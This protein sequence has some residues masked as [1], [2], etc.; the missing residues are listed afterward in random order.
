MTTRPRI[1]LIVYVCLFVSGAATLIYELIWFR[2]LTLVFGASLYAL[3]A[4]LCAFMLGLAGGAWAM[5][6]VLARDIQA[7]GSKRLILWYGLL[8]AMIGLYAL[9][10]PFGLELLEKIYPLLLPADGQAGLGLHVTEF[11]LGTFLMLPATLLMGAT[12][13]LIGCWAIGSQKQQLFSKLSLLY[14]WNTIGAVFG[15]LFTQFFAI[16]IWGVQGAIWFAVLLNALVF[17][18]CFVGSRFFYP[19]ESAELQNKS[20]V[21]KENKVSNRESPPSGIVGILI[22]VMFAY[23]GMASLSSEILWTRILVFPMGTTLYSFALILA[24][25]LSGIALGSLAAKRLL[26]ESNWVLK[27]ILIEILIGLVCIGILPLLENLTEWTSLADRFFYSIEN[28]PEKTLFIRFLFAFGLMFLPTFGFGLLFPLA[29]HI[30]LFRL[31]AVSQAIG[32]A[33]SINTL[34]GVLGTILTP[35]VFIPLFGIR[36]SIYLIYTVLILLGI[37]VLA[38]HRQQKFALTS[39]WLGAALVLLVLGKSIF[40]PDIETK[41]S[42]DHNLARLE[43]NVPEDKIQLLDYKEGEFSTIS[44]VE[45]KESGARTL[46]LDGFSTAT[47]SRSFSGSTYMQAMGFVPMALHPSPKKV[48]VIGFG[49]GNT[50]GIASLFPGATIHGV[51]I[52]KNVLKFSKWFSS[53]NHDVLERPNTRVFIQDGRAFLRWSDIQYDVIIMEPMSPLQAGVVNLYSKE[54]YELALDHLK[55]D[56]ILVQW[57]PLHLVGR[58]DARSIT[59]TFKNVFPEFSVWNSFLTRIVLLIGSREKV[60]IDKN[61]FDAKLEEPQLKKVAEEMKVMSFLDFADFFITDGHRLSGFLEGAGEI[62]DDRPLLE[63]STVSLLPPLKW[64]TDESF[65]NML[66]HR[67][68]QAPPVKGLSLEEQKVFDRN[69]ML[70]T[71]QRL[72]VF[73][74]RYQGPGEEAFVARNYFAGLEEMNIYFE[75]YKKPQVH[76]DEAKWQK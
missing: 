66:R 23:S 49:T 4:V 74:R 50:L 10:F 61:L 75:N 68:N 41:K 1:N 36:L 37:F 56:G 27:F 3:S 76:L 51:E 13:P 67:I 34:G 31:E 33:Y 54:F 5:G 72:G 43:I 40:V 19:E 8:E 22:F 17:L 32:N 29:N 38:K 70:R 71:A 52:D 28:S 46:Y 14:G 26:G 58:E 53:W 59:Q 42:G 21:E 2:Y 44:V 20:N 39:I 9:C 57:L 63:F 45:D 55:K 18:V 15:C 12:L 73:S 65:L 60:A 7:P 48:L 47:V 30:Y 62:S 35:F 11:V 25:F 6:R 16:R 64:E 69:F 24:T